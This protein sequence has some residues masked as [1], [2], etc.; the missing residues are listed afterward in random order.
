[1]VQFHL[2]HA[3]CRISINTSQCRITHAKKKGI[4]RKLNIVLI[5]LK[6]KKLFESK[7]KHL[8]EGLDTIVKV[9]YMVV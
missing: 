5:V 9:A 7:D 3:Q 6:V 8:K 4:M 2:V 1:M